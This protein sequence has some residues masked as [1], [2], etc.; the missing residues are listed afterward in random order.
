MSVCLGLKDFLEQGTISTKAG[1]VLGKPGQFVTLAHIHNI[2]YFVHVMYYILVIHVFF[3]L[4]NLSHLA[5]F[6]YCAI[7]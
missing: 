3:P 6:F 1:L 7:I 2:L 4:N 5:Q